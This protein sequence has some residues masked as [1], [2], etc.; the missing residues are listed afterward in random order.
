MAQRL[1]WAHTLFL[2]HY[3]SFSLW[4]PRDFPRA[5]FNKCCLCRL[6]ILALKQSSK[7]SKVNTSSGCYIERKAGPPVIR[8]C[9][10]S[11]PVIQCDVLLKLQ[12]GDGASE[13]WGPSVVR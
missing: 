3:I 1:I 7:F 8:G 4:Y 9:V 10:L 5:V 12:D 11:F 13:D 6:C 2:Y